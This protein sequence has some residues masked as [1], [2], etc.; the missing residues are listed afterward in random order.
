MPTFSRSLEQ[1]IHR[2]LA[3][4]NERDHEYATLEH[5]L[6]ALIDDVDALAAM[7][8]WEVDLGVLKEKLVSHLDNEL[9]TLVTDDGRD[10]SPSPALQRVV[11]RA[12]LHVGATS[13]LELTGR[14]VLA[15]M[16][17]ETDSLAVRLLGEKALS[18]R[19]TKA[20]MPERGFGVGIVRQSFSHGRTKPV[21]VEKVKRRRSSTRT[22]D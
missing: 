15:A 22:G 21:V 1:S 4:A 19:P 7:K 16:L 6:L 3:L 13:A 8:A 11:Q 10:S 12:V 18:I 2:A 9:K 14:D 5:M 20:P 17:A